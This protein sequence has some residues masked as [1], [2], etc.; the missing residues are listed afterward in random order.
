[1]QRTDGG[2]SVERRQLQEKA[3]LFAQRGV[4][5]LVTLLAGLFIGYQLWGQAGALKQQV[6][7]MEERVSILQKERDTLN[8]QKAI[9]DRDKKEVEKRLQ[10]VQARCAA[11]AEAA[12]ATQP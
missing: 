5:L 3:W 9:I 7:Q 4:V 8:S 6:A 12:P 1:M 10:D 11:P 2:G